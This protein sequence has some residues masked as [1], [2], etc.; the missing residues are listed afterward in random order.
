MET[1]TQELIFQIITIVI[2][3]GLTALGVYAKKLITTKIDVTKYGFEND[4]IERILDNA[5]NYAE[6]K[7]IEHA[8]AGAIKLA[9]NEKL[10]MARKYLDKVDPTII[11][12][13][14]NQIDDMISRKVIQVI[15]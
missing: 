14:G 1:A 8:K 11:A 15:K 2:S 3:L 13:Y 4:R 6:G 7:A 10:G 9:G 5:V 12:K